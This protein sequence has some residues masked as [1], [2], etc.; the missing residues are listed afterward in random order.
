MKRT[1]SSRLGQP[2]DR[3]GHVEHPRRR[4]ATL[5]ILLVIVVAAAI[6]FDVWSGQRTFHVFGQNIPVAAVDSVV[7]KPGQTSGVRVPR[8]AFVTVT[9]RGQ[10]L[11]LLN[12]LSQARPLKERVPSTTNIQ[13]HLVHINI[14]GRRSVVCTLYRTHQFP[15]RMIALVSQHTYVTPSALGR[16]LQALVH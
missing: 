4:L 2:V 15:L 8:S 9:Q 16:V 1:R 10:V 7:V 3:P 13:T 12:L 5:P 11:Q 14:H 6:G